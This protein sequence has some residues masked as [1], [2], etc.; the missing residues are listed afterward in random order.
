MES[1][2]IG[3]HWRLRRHQRESR[4]RRFPNLKGFPDPPSVHIAS[5]GFVFLS[6][7]RLELSYRFFEADFASPR[8]RPLDLFGKVKGIDSKTGELKVRFA[9]SYP[10]VLTQKA[11]EDYLADEGNGNPFTKFKLTCVPTKDSP[12]P[13]VVLLTINKFADD[14]CKPTQF[15]GIGK[16]SVIFRTRYKS[17]NRMIASFG[18]DDDQ[19]PQ[20]MVD[21]DSKKD[22]ILRMNVKTESGD[23]L[24]VGFQIGDLK[25]D[26]NSFSWRPK[27]DLLY[28]LYSKEIKGTIT[29]HD[30]KAAR[31]VATFTSTFDEIGFERK[32]KQSGNP[33]P[34]RKD[35]P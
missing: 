21:E 11:F 23:Y 24:T 10:E 9:V 27:N 30:G 16:S 19:R 33:E 3:N 28:A 29:F 7:M 5:S 1:K 15:E 31:T 2:L 25:E 32:K 18:T 14:R 26:E 4:C 22:S 35:S 20:T 8:N 12:I 13:K 17:P 6:K 34:K